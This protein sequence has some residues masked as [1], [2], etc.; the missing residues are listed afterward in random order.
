MK[1]IFKNVVIGLLATTLLLG[2]CALPTDS[3]E[4]TEQV[5][6][7]APNDDDN[8]EQVTEE[9]PVASLKLALS[10]N[11]AT[12]D[13]FPHKITEGRMMKMDNGTQ[14]TF[15]NNATF[16]TDAL[17]V[18]RTYEVEGVLGRDMISIVGAD[19]DFNIIAKNVAIVMA[20]QG[21]HQISIEIELKENGFPKTPFD[22]TP[23]VS[24]ADSTTTVTGPQYTPIRHDDGTCFRL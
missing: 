17:E 22:F 7:T 21:T 10:F 5:L 15:L 9:D 1:K 18:G 2:S 3:N 24:G 13:V 4:K 19:K 8:K 6:P 14:M 11:D 23:V 16:N 20:T 12:A